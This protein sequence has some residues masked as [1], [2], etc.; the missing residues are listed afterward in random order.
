MEVNHSFI[1]RFYMDFSRLFVDYNF[2]LFEILP[3]PK[4]QHVNTLNFEMIYDAINENHLLTLILQTGS[5]RSQISRYTNIEHHLSIPYHV[6][7]SIHFRIFPCAGII[8]ILNHICVNVIKK[9]FNKKLFSKF[10]KK[11]YRAYA[12]SSSWSLVGLIMTYY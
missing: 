4:I 2:R 7:F 5:A 6:I 12:N 10:D 1:M 9:R 3:L 8:K 11:N